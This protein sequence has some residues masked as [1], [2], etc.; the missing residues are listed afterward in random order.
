MGKIKSE[1]SVDVC[2]SNLTGQDIIDFAEEIK[3]RG[4]EADKIS[5]DVTSIPPDRER[6]IFFTKYDVILTHRG[7]HL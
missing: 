7:D 6:G 5:C 3:R 4:G 2:V 1:I